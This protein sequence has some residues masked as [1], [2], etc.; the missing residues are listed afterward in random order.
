MGA[1]RTE[2]GW[3]GHF[4]CADRCLFRRNTLVELG[5]NRVIISTVGRMRDIHTRDKVIFE[6]IGCD[7]H[8][9]T[10]V[11]K[12]KWEAPYW[13]TDVGEQLN[14]DAEWCISDVVLDS[15]KRAD[16]M[17]EAVVAEFISKMEKT[18]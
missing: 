2:R 1:I 6:E 4:I 8:Y 14:F 9:E 12:A 13:E 5:D 11:F 16:E 15:D 3:A 17:H 10:M 18:K 7:R